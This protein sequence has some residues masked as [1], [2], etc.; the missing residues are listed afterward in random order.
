VSRL[1][2][3]DLARLKAEVSL[4]SLVEARGVELRKAG[5][6]LVGRCPFHDDRSPSLVVSPARTCGTASGSARAVGR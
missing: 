2:E 4:V 5:A 3:A 6:D 1:S